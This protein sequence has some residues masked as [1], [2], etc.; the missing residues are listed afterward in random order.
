[1]SNTELTLKSMYERFI[2]IEEEMSLF[3]LKINNIHFW[4]RIRFNAFQIIFYE[5]I[6]PLES[7]SESR[8]SPPPKLINYFIKAKN[9]LYSLVRLGKNPFI[10]RKKDI[11]ILSNPKRK[12]Q[13][14]GKWWDVYTD[15]FI[16]KLNYSAVSIE[17]D[18]SLQYLS[19][20]QTKNLKYFAFASLLVEIKRL[21]KKG[22]V[23]LNSNDKDVLE[24]ISS[25]FQKFFEIK[26]DLIILVTN[27]LTRRSRFL[28]LYFSILKRIKPKIVIVICSYGKEDFIEAC[29]AKEIPVIELQHGVITRYHVGYSYEKDKARKH[30]FPDYFFSFG[31][32]WKETVKYPIDKSKIF[33]IG[34][35]E[36]EK[37]KEELKEVKKEKQILFISQKTIGYNLSKFASNL[38]KVDN[39]D[40]K[41]IYKLHPSECE[42][43]Q[44]N[45]PWL[46]ESDIEVVEFSGKEIYQLFAESEIQIG[47]YST[48]IFEGLS[49]DLKTFLYEAPGIEYMQPL[50][51]GGFVTKICD[52][53][54][55]LE[56][57]KTKEM[58]KFDSELLFK[59]NSLENIK[60]KIDEIIKIK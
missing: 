30:T 23:T 24:R 54:D 41:I 11:L 21:F 52:T 22:K 31:E 12:L 40:Y 10:A 42:D 37:K 53:E 55:F 29:K 39:L 13:S 16:D 6:V 27:I 9:Y 18:F 5:K 28:P 45:F 8:V 38:S 19:P 1:M 35:P 47:V 14:N 56:K 34:Y 26:L 20:P 59:S 33:N 32:F 2:Q 36:W 43:W 7:G 44:K 17:S 51:E 57:M 15:T 3:E 58:K 60:S 48:A 46:E 25:E 4:E 49:F 50:V